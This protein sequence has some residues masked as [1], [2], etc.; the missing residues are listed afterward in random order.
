M[1]QIS[2]ATIVE[3]VT[4]DNWEFQLTPHPSINSRLKRF[5]DIVGSLVGLLILSIVFVPIAI[6]IIIDSPGP[7]FFTQERYGLYGRSFCIRKFRSMVSDAEKL[8]SLVENEA[9]GLIFKNKNDFRVTRVGRF[10]RSTSLDE[11]PQ[12]WNVLVGEMSLVGTRPPTKDEVCHYN[13]R[14]W[15][16]LNVKPGLTGEWQINGRSYVKNFEQV[17]DLDLQYQ[18]KWHPM[19]DLL[20][21]VKTFFII[22]GRVGAF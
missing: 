17:V 12:F 8:K 13:Q 9:D 5:L 7:I 18:K 4:A 11:L 6:A 1:Y 15:Q 2:C 3:G 21:I 20:L 19:Y 10:L 14:H 16:R 22:F